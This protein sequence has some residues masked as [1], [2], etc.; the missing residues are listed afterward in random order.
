[1]LAEQ[2]NP[3]FMTYDADLTIRKLAARISKR[4]GLGG[5]TAAIRFALSF[6]DSAQRREPAPLDYSKCNSDYLTDLVIHGD[7]PTIRKAA[8]DELM[9]RV[10]YGKAKVTA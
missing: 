6:T 7:V 1:M 2:T 3:R 8:L 5:Q 9:S 4:N 10:I